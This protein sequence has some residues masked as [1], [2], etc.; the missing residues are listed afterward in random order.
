MTQMTIPSFS[1]MRVTNFFPHLLYY[2]VYEELNL[3]RILSSQRVLNQSL[4]L[5]ANSYPHSNY[6]LFLL[7]FI[8]SSLVL[9][10]MLNGSSSSYSVWRDLYKYLSILHS[11]L[12]FSFLN[13]QKAIE[14]D[15]NIN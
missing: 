14:R 8:F 12:S 5:K 11:C 10:V 7:I 9:V 15:W 4:Q 2:K 1:R 3:L 6:W 13:W